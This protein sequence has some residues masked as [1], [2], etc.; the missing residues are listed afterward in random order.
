MLSTTGPGPRHDKTERQHNAI[1]ILL[2]ARTREEACQLIGISRQSLYSWFKEEEFM[3][4][5]RAAQRDLYDAAMNLMLDKLHR[6]VEYLNGVIEDADAPHQVKIQAAKIVVER[7]TAV[8]D[9]AD[10]EERI[11]ELE[12]LAKSNLE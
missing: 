3:R 6:A 7:C 10:L 2:T 5:Y 4:M 12:R 1:P 11:W 9:S 8:A